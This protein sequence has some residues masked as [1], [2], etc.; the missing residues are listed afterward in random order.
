MLHEFFQFAA[1]NDVLTFFLFIVVGG[2]I[3]GCFKYIAY[4]LRGGKNFPKDDDD[5]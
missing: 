2:T 5:E 4:A 1:A 3:V